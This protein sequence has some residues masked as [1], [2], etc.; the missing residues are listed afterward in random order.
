MTI[1]LVN[2]Q[3]YTCDICRKSIILEREEFAPAGWRHLEY[4]Y[5]NDCDFKVDVCNV[6]VSTWFQGLE[7]LAS[8]SIK[9]KEERLKRAHDYCEA[10]S[11][12]VE[13]GF[14]QAE[15]KACMYQATI[16]ALN[17]PQDES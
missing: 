11:A 6:C 9:A 15:Y 3:R 13:G 5:V 2:R 7:G 8:K 12:Q 14:S 4:G 16:D 1:D 10:R 17:E